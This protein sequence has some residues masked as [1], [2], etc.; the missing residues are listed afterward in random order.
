M[1]IKSMP[2]DDMQLIVFAIRGS[3]SFMDWAVNFD[4]RPEQP[5]GFRVCDSMNHRI[6]CPLTC[7]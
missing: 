5:E 4:T 6:I 3:Q 1:V 7:V 2:L